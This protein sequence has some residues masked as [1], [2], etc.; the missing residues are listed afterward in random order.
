MVEGRYA[1]YGEGSCRSSLYGSP[2]VV[3]PRSLRVLFL[4]AIGVDVPIN[5]GDSSR[6]GSSSALCSA[7]VAAD[8]VG[9]NGS[10]IL[11]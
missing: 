3:F 2:S 7:M 8:S 4:G 11:R 9:E 10:T 1:R 6:D 5:L